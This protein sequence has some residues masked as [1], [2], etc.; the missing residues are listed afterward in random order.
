MDGR[1]LVC[2]GKNDDVIAAAEVWDRTGEFLATG[3]MTSRRQLHT[4]TLLPGGWS[5]S[6]VAT[7][8]SGRSPLR[9]YTTR[10]AASSIGRARCPAGAKATLHAPSGRQSPGRGWRQ[11]RGR[12]RHGRHMQPGRQLVSQRR[13][14]GDRSRRPHGDT[15][16]IRDRT[17]DRRRGRGECHQFR[18]VL[19]PERWRVP[20]SGGHES[21]PRRTYRHPHNHGLV[22]IVGERMTRAPSLRSRPSIRNRYVC[23]CRT[24]QD[25]RVDHT[26]N[27]LPDGRVLIAVTG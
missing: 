18:R 21:R 9:R 2:G 3:P 23:G 15:P 11:R 26:A 27:L 6:S 25:A 10:Q 7:M 4:A 12:K 1:V 14:V 17:S 24:P 16:P 20:F 8:V 19:R 22:L 13:I 5:S